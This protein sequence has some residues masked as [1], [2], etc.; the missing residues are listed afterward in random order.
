M[1]MVSPFWF[2]CLFK[3]KLT[4]IEAHYS[5]NLCHLFAAVVIALLLR[6]IRDNMKSRPM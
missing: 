2:L 1:F 6:Q 3:N 4:I 5:F